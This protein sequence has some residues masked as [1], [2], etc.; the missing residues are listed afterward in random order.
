MEI[1]LNPVT[2]I[3]GLG[4]FLSALILAWITHIFSKRRQIDELLF[5]ARKRPTQ[6]L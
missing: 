5:V 6:S 1:I 2:I 3:V 4:G